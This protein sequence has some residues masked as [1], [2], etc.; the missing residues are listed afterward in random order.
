MK[1]RAVS[2]ALLVVLAGLALAA[3]GAPA[4]VGAA[5]RP[6]AQAEDGLATAGANNSSMGSQIS[7]F[8]QASAGEAGTSV[9]SGMWNARYERANGS[10]RTAVVEARIAS[11][12]D[13]LAALQREKAE[14]LAAKRNG[15]VNASVFRARMSNIVGQLAAV[16]RSIEEAGTQAQATGADMSL[17]DEL[18]ANASEMTGPQVAAVAR[19]IAG[20]P[21][22]GLPA[23]AANGSD[24][25][26]GGPPD[27]TPGNGTG[28]DN[29]DNGQG[30]GQGSALLAE[31]AGY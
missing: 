11:L 22:A 7:A 9:R 27:D 13:R 5:D 31:P 21:P 6:A 8:M 15:T 17:V 24:R 25:G 3:A 4:T 30:S 20:G 10:A 2:L 14:L 1:V 23:Q 18:R 29:D 26:G 28:T 16:N 12:Q 19:T